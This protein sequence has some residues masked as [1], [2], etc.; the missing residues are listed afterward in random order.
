M[1][2]ELDQHEIECSKIEVV[3]YSNTAIADVIGNGFFIVDQQWKVSSW[4]NIAEKLLGISADDMI[5]KN[6]WV[7]FK[8]EIPEVF[9]TA[10][11]EVLLENIPVHFNIYW[12]ERNSW[13]DVTTCHFDDC[14]S[15]SFKDSYD[16]ENPPPSVR[17]LKSINDMY[18]LVTEVTSDCLWEWDLLLGQILWID[19]GHKRAFGYP[20]ENA[21]IPKRFWEAR[22]H[23]ED[24]GRV[25]TGLHAFF[26]NGMAVN[27]EEEYRFRKFNGDYAYV[28]VR[29][30]LVYNGDKR[31]S[32][33]IGAT[34]DI[35]ARKSAEAQLHKAEADLTRQ[36]LENQKQ[37]FAA[38]LIAQE[39]ERNLI[40]AEMHDNVNQILV[41]T[42][43]LLSVARTDVNSNAECLERAIDNIQNAIDETRRIAHEL[44]APD[45]EGADLAS[46][47]RDLGRDMLKTA[48]ID[49][50]INTDQ[51]NDN[52]LGSEL[53][54]SA[55][56]IVQ[57]QFTNIV[58]YSHA[59]VVN[60]LLSTSSDQFIMS[61]ADD[62]VGMAEGKI[63]SGIGLRNVKARVAVLNGEAVVNSSDV[64]GFKLE[65]NVPLRN[66][67][68]GQNRTLDM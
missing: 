33:M 28:H 60:I 15:V 52:L 1:S 64:E 58:K 14:L 21:L 9:Y 18:R 43:L 4:N 32:L 45:I 55:Y 49:V 5:G 13:F 35:S 7:Q 25:L 65:I 61:I 41:A 51:L 10:Y 47:V 48:G 54:L 3:H 34:Q 17:Q 23:P 50:Y 22:L 6:I 27:W 26:A 53:K 46:M 38:I 36:Q 11:H 57:E 67:M 68:S 39:K 29:G 37:I 31:T 24:K 59:N 16:G 62:G 30:Q 2:Y 66:T 8:K 40:G 19:G 56:R 20:I 12:E 42:K 44:A 63:I